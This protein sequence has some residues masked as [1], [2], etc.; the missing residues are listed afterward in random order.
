MTFKQ[1]FSWC[2]WA[3]AQQNQQSDLCAQRRLGSA[4]ASIQSDQSSQSAWKNLGSLATHWAHSEDSD[5]TG[6]IPRLIYVFA[7]HTGHIVGFLIMWL[8]YQLYWRMLMS[9]DLLSHDLYTGLKLM[10]HELSHDWLVLLYCPKADVTWLITWL[11]CL[12]ILP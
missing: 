10:S 11:T 5:Q 1:V 12:V 7:G 8:N 6:W 9:H 4:W 2:G 3:T